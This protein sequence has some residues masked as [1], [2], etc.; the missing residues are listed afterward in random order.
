VDGLTGAALA[1]ATGRPADAWPRRRPSGS[2]ASSPT[3][4]TALGWTLHLNGRDA[5]A[6]P[7]AQRAFD[8]GAQ[9]A[10][11]AYHLG[12]IQLALGDRAG[13]RANLTRALEISPRSR[14]STRRGRGPP[15]P[16]WGPE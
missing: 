3:W 9:S 4:P 7:Y 16:G 15:W 13:A 1:E 11:Y 5:E 2:G 6:L 10:P 14:R 12:I 8:T